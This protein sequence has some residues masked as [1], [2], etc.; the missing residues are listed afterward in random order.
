MTYEELEASTDA[1]VRDYKDI[2]RVAEVGRSRC[3]EKIR[4]VIIGKG[5]RTALLFGAPHPNEPIGTLT[6]EYLTKVAAS[7]EA[8]RKAL[9]YTWVIVKV[10]DIDGLKM[11]EGWFKKPFSVRTYAENYY[12]P[13]GNVQI[14][15]SFPIK[16]KKYYFGNLTPGTKALMNL[17]D[18]YKPDFVYSLYNTG[19]GGV[20]Y[21]ITTEAPLLYPIFQLYPKILIV[22]LSLGEPE[23]PWARTL[24]RAVYRMVSVRD[25]YDFIDSQGMD[26][27]E[28]IKHEGSSFDYARE[29]NQSAIELVTEVP[30]LYDP[31]I[32]DLN[33]ADVTRRDAVLEAIK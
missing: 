25:Y 9:D 2:V 28:V 18:T 1:L 10:V 15:W 27:L 17:M 20:N 4:A 24:S 6:L 21:Y 30:Y 3:G 31:R 13:A 5:S 12:R 14:E 32:E 22:P 11:N 7:D 19:F 8:V 23:V 29:L 33:E 26:P 16:Y